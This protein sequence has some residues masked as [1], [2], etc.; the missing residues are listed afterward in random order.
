MDASSPARKAHAHEIHEKAGSISDNLE[1]LRT[2]MARNLLPEH[3]IKLLG[4]KEGVVLEGAVNHS[5][6]IA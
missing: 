6:V 4:V 2:A 1:H 3:N 5:P